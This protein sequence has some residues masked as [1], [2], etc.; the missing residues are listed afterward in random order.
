MC[1][2]VTGRHR[3]GHLA[4]YMGTRACAARFA[5]LKCEGLTAET[6]TVNS[7]CFRCCAEIREAVERYHWY[8]SGGR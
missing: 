1:I 7:D 5:G 8:E 4:G 6:E 2:Q 3:C